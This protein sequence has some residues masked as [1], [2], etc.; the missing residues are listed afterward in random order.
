[1]TGAPETGEETGPR[2]RW[3]DRIPD[4]TALTRHGDQPGTGEPIDPETGGIIDPSTGQI[5]DPGTGQVIG[6]IR[7]SGDT[8]GSARRRD[9]PGDAGALRWGDRLDGRRH[10]R[11]RGPGPGR[12]L[13]HREL[14]G[15]RPQKIQ[16]NQKG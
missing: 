6:Q 8:A 4:R 7:G 11:R 12:R 13:Y 1:M 10:R 15:S 14:S 16:M 3:G 5:L 9:R 2:H